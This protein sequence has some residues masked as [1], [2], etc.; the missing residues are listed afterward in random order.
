[1]I[2]ARFRGLEAWQRNQYV[3]TAVVFVLQNKNQKKN[4][5]ENG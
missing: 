3:M 4:Q 5:E 1:L 2:A